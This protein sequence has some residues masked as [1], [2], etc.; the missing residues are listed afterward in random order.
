MF[1]F[2]TFIVFLFLSKQVLAQEVKLLNSQ[3]IPDYIVVELKSIAHQA[4]EAEIAI[5]SKSRSVEKQVQVMLDYYILCTKGRFSY[6]PEV[7]GIKL[8]KQVY[9][10]NCHG[11]FDKF[12]PD[13]PRQENVRLMTAALTE[14]LIKLG[15]DRLCMNHVVIPGVKTKKIAVD[16]KPSSVSNYHKFYNAVKANSKVIE[17]YY[18]DIKGLPTSQVKESAFHIEFE[19]E[20]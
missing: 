4:G 20:E 6:Q 17:F 11:G 1:R 14:S 15:E 12:D 5:S 8:A 2:A 18:P 16:I 9:H 3:G 13:R 19:R 7:C 10:P